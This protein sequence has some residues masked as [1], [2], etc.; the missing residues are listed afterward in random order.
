MS[1]KLEEK[2]D[3]PLLVAF[4]EEEKV[5]EDF[6]IENLT[7]DHQLQKV[8]EPFNGRTVGTRCHKTLTTGKKKPKH[9]R[10]NVIDD[11]KTVTK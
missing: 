9:D 4:S 10:R 8:I 2:K 5:I 6:D 7:Y 11:T 3:L 1:L